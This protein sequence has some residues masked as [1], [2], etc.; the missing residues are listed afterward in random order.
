MTT[1]SLALPGPR[2]VRADLLK[3]RRRRSLVVVVSLLTIGAVVI[4]NAVLLV[5]HA[6]DAA[7]HGPAGG[8][9]NLGHTSFLL[10]GLGSVAAVLVGTWAGIGD[11]DAGVYRDLV[12]TGRSRRALYLSRLPGGLLFLLPFVAVAYALAAVASVAFAGSLPV[13]GTTLLAETGLWILL[14]TTFYYVLSLGLAAAIGSRSQ[15]IGIVLA[16]RLALT[17]I[18]LS[19]SALGLVRE[20]VPG[21]ALERFAPHTLASDLT[22]GPH[23]AMSRAAALA[24]LLV[25]TAVA[26][27][28]GL[29]R[30]ARRDA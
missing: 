9:V 28:M 24:V 15:T 18:L 13:A 23:I 16:W 5:L 12:V 19:I 3:L 22:Q 4:T 26:F 30:D 10:S 14:S 7:K 8:I 27:R 29:W 17:P 11:R 6:I 2:L 25:W 21:A 20:L 1:A